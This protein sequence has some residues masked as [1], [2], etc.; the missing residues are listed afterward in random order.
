MVSCVTGQN[1]FDRYCVEARLRSYRD[2]L[3]LVSFRCPTSFVLR[4]IPPHMVAQWWH[5]TINVN[6]S[7]DTSS[8]PSEWSVTCTQHGSR[9]IFE[10]VFFYFLNKLFLSLTVPFAGLKIVKLTLMLCNCCTL[11]NVNLTARQTQ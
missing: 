2:S 11:F 10:D 9:Y 5:F 1:E 3:C 8:H 4:H 7:L 6:L